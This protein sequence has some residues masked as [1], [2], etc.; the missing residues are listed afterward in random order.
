M[1]SPVTLN[2]AAKARAVWAAGD[3]TDVAARL[4]PE[5]GALLVG[6]AGVRPGQRVL[7]VAA[8]AG[9]VAIPAAAGTGAEVVALDVGPQLLQTGRA[10]AEQR[11][12]TVE[13]VEGD[14]AALPFAD[15]AFDV[16]LSCVGVMFA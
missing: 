4:I 11:G 10:L 16:V 14:A 7:D 13:W 15:A 8:G 3:Y 12:V 6:A 9:N 2:P 5:L 1:S